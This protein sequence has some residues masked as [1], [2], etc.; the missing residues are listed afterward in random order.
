MSAW[1]DRHR[2]LHP[3]T[4]AEPGPW[5]TNRTPYLRDVLDAFS[6][7]TVEQLTIMASTQVGKTEAIMNMIAYTIAEDPGATLL[8]MPREEDA[9]QMGM[10]RI[11]P[12]VESSPELS[13]HL[14]ESKSDNKL[15]EI[16]FTRSMLY[17]AGSNSPADL[18]SRPVRYVLG[19]EV[20]KW[21]AF[22]GRESSPVDLMVERTRTFWNRKIVLASTPT[23]RNGYIFQ[24]YERSDQRVYSV[25]CPHCEHSQTLEFSQVKW[26]D[27]ERDP[28]KIRQERLA[29]YECSKCSGVIKDRDK[30]EMLMR[31]S[32]SVTGTPGSHRGYRINALLSPWLTWSEVA[33]KFLESK[34]NPASLMNFV[35]SWL[36]W[37]FEEESHKVEVDD[38]SQRAK[39]YERSTVPAGARVLVAGVDVQQDHL[40]YIVRAFGY[41]EESWLIE[42]GR[43]NAGLEQLVDVLLRRTWPGEQGPHRLRLACI[44]SGYRTDEVYRFCRSWPEICRPIKGQKS[45]N[46]VPIRT[47]KIDRNIAG[48]PL[49]GS[50]R[51]FHLDT[52]H[53]KD[54]VT[55]FMTAQ[56]GEPGAWHLHQDV[57]AE[58]LKQVTSEHKVLTRNRRTGATASVWT[59]KPGGSDNHYW[60]CEVYAAASADM[61]AVFALTEEAHQ[62]PEPPPQP[63]QQSQWVK[64][65]KGWI[66]G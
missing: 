39:E 18:A 66:N 48:D 7:P 24:Q 40:Y 62:P 43:L 10:R 17:L 51:L 54:K 59:T 12:M 60:D 44:D 50:V 41:R 63:S 9:V 14:S 49:K 58:Y 45:L 13:K 3:L 23:T 33:A 16:R 31:G 52:T 35:N 8:V 56:D 27:D 57:P 32:W 34:S 5:N 20:D 15:K 30:P 64:P 37:I 65:G 29:W 46:G 53:F 19:D 55:R 11:R 4:S 42:C 26:P 22:S 28:V 21:P 61:V 38:L 2:I 1:A 25:P 47:S 6:D 36:G